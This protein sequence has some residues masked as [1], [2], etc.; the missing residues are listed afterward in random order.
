MLPIPIKR[1]C[2]SEYRIN[3]VLKSTYNEILNDEYDSENALQAERFDAM[4]GKYMASLWE[5]FNDF[6]AGQN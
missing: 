1:S 4:W 5:N 3:D 2:R 6:K